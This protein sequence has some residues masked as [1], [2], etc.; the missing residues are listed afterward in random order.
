MIEYIK[1][2]R[3]EAG[4][5]NYPGKEEVKNNTV[6]TIVVCAASALLLW[7]VSELILKLISVVVG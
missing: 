6:T 5:I 1:N 4:K 3:A 7:G 2:V